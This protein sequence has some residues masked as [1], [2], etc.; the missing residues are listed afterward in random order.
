MLA[1]PKTMDST[2]ILVTFITVA[3]QP[4]RTHW[5]AFKASGMSLLVSTSPKTMNF[6]ILSVALGLFYM[7]PLPILR[8]RGV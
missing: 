4:L 1:I 8:A 2:V 3:C 5:G 6:T 7:P